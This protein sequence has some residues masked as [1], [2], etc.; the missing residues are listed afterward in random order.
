MGEWAGKG[1]EGL[2]C[3]EVFLVGGGRSREG[4]PF[5]EWRFIPILA[6]WGGTIAEWQHRNHPKEG[7]ALFP[8]G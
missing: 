1:V 6:I 4:V 2:K 5:E 8:R 7:A 3:L